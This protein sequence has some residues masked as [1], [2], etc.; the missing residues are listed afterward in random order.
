VS[1]GLSHGWGKNTYT[2]LG[3]N[4]ANTIKSISL[5]IY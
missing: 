5:Q 1:L 2:Q 3:L 4:E